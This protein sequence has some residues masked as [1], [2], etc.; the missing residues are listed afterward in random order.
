MTDLTRSEVA[1]WI[2]TL[3]P[4]LENPIWISPKGTLD[5]PEGSVEVH[6][7]KIIDFDESLLG[8]LRTLDQTENLRIL[9][10]LYKSMGI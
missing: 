5:S 4:Y 1:G 8:V 9:I 7:G 6:P 3:V 10:D 2:R